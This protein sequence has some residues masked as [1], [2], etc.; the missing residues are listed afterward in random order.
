MADL[1]SYT[2]FAFI[3]LLY[4]IFRLLLL[5]GLFFKNQCTLIIITCAGCSINE[6]SFEAVLQSGLHVETFRSPSDGDDKS[7]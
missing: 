1:I 5:K 3:R 4:H 6:T 2:I 7:R